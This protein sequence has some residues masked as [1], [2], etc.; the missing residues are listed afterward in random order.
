MSF[1]VT[2]LRELLKIFLDF[3]EC[4]WMNLIH[5]RFDFGHDL[6]LILI[7]GS[8][9]ISGFAMPFDPRVDKIETQHCAWLNKQTN[10]LD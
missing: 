7:L 10:K 6:K 2:I 9:K 3:E 5:Y 1:L 8:R 4:I